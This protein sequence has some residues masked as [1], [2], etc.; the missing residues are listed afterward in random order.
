[1]SLSETVARFVV[2][3]REG[4][5][6]VLQD[7][8]GRSYDIALKDVPPDCRQEGAV[9]DVPTSSSGDPVWQK[10]VRNRVE[11]AVRL[12]ESTS[13]LERLRRSDPGGDI[14]L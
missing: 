8:G 4:K 14:E 1:M 3:R 10:A 9:L 7:E 5:T 13:R 11:E 2:D 12:R 6:L